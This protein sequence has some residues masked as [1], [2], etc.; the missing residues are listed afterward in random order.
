[1]W[2]RVK[3]LAQVQV[4]NIYCSSFCTVNLDRLLGSKSILTNRFPAQAPRNITIQRYLQLHATFS[5]PILTEDTKVR[6]DDLCKSVEN[7][8]LAQYP[9]SNHEIGPAEHGN[10]RNIFLPLTDAFVSSRSYWIFLPWICLLPYW[11]LPCQKCL[12]ASRTQKVGYREGI[13]L[14]SNCWQKIG[15]SEGESWYGRKPIKISEMHAC[16]KTKYI[17]V[18]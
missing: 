5:I 3:G 10:C 14:V 15:L 9:I 4:G 7:I 2:G 12:S 8:H 6:K 11:M 16:S 17:A 1:M 18:K 13:W